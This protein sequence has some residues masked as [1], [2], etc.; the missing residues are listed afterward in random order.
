MKTKPQGR[1]HDTK[2]AVVCEPLFKK[3]GAETHLKYI[4]Q[5]FPNSEIFAAYYDENFVKENFP[6]AKIHHS[7]MQYLPKKEYLRELYLLFQPTAY[8]SFK[9]KSYDIVISLSIAFAKFVN[10]KD[11]KHI[12][13]CMSPPKFLWQ[14]EG[15]TLQSANQ[16]TGFKRNI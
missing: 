13:I 4:L 12:D 10:P 15:R 9:F 1:M 8:K 16:Y 7:F 14:K 6:D 11:I 5:A 2:V 3:G